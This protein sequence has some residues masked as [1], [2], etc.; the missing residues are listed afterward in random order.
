MKKLY[1]FGTDSVMIKFQSEKSKKKFEREVFKND[2]KYT[3]TRKKKQAKSKKTYRKFR[4]NYTR[5]RK[6]PQANKVYV[7]ERT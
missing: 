5:P 7:G 6:K 1:Y 3:R 4:K 2:K